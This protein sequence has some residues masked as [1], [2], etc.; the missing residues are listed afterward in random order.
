MIQLEGD[1]FEVF[2]EEGR[3][4]VNTLRE[5]T[6]K[7][8]K[9][10]YQSVMYLDKDDLD[11]DSAERILSF[12]FKPLEYNKNIIASYYF[13]ILLIELGEE[14]YLPMDSNFDNICMP[15]NRLD[16]FY[17]YL[18]LKNNYY[19]SQLNFSVSSTNQNE[20]AKIYITGITKNN[21]SKIIAEDYFNYIYVYNENFSDIEYFIITFEFKNF[22]LKS[23]ISSFCDRVYETYPQIYSTQMF[24]INNFT[25]IYHFQLKHSF[26][27]YYQHLGG[28]SGIFGDLYSADNFKGKL[29]SIP[30]ENGIDVNI[31]V[32][33]N[34]FTYYIHLIPNPKTIKIEELKQGKPL[35]K[36]MNKTSFPLY[37]YY[38]LLYK[39]RDYVNIN[40]NLRFSEDNKFENYNYSVKGYIIDEDTLNK[41][42][43]GENIKIPPPYEGNY[44]DAYGIA[45]LQINKNMTEDDYL[46]SQY[47]LIVLEKNDNI[48]DKS[49]LSLFFVE[50]MIKEL[51]NINGFFLPQHTYFIDT[52]D[53]AKK[54]IRA[55]NIYSIFNPKADAIQPVIE[56]SSQYNNTII[57]FEDV[58]ICNNATENLTGFR[59]YTI[60]EN[61]KT[62]IYFKV[63]SSGI[64][65]NYMIMYY[66]N[67]I[68]DNYLIKLD[69]N[70]DKKN[71]DNN[72]KLTDILF[73]FNGISVIN[74]GEISLIFYITGSLYKSDEKSFELI[75][76]TCFLHE[77]QQAFV[78]EKTNST[79]NNTPGNNKSTEFTLIFK[80]IPKENNYIY[81][82]RIQMKARAFVDFF[83]EEYLSFTVKADLTDIKKSD[84]KWLT[85]AI[86]VIVV[87][88]GLIIALV[89]LIIKFLILRK[90]NTNL[91]DEIVSLAFSNDVQKNVLS[92]ESKISRNESDFESTFI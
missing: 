20:Y 71:V 57:E 79:F 89:F 4:K 40:A 41:K 60:C 37:Y 42:I 68:K 5:E 65:T 19:E 29:I 50:T 87:G 63:K 22:G 3:Q 92:K 85:W 77:H 67:D 70:Y 54:K 36:F 45:Y 17:C 15:L 27:G 32:I 52:F 43:D 75:N 62:T 46:Q 47:L 35:I 33:T 66:L 9:K 8:D 49:N 48:Q 12:A 91:K 84:L 90:K 73:K 55:D 26:L 13:R 24:Y 58:N 81:D 16:N 7:L 34:E 64:K 23:I 2:Y 61:T 56:L 82:L 53:D 18:I 6:K 72:E 74:S 59:K 78:S 83:K 86:P 76:S 38:K 80:N 14:E 1:Y 10:D 51:D 30:I 28:K 25:K 88:V 21:E 69:V 11:F 44:S 39:D 31:K